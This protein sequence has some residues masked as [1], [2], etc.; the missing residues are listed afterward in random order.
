MQGKVFIQTGKGP[1]SASVS[2]PGSSLEEQSKRLSIQQPIIQ[3][4]RRF[5]GLSPSKNPLNTPTKSALHTED[6]DNESKPAKIMRTQ[7]SPKTTAKRR[8][9]TTKSKKETPKTPTQIIKIP[10]IKK[11][12]DP[13]VA[14]RRIKPVTLPL[15]DSFKK[16][17]ST[18]KLIKFEP[19]QEDWDD[20]NVSVES[21]ELRL[22][23][24]RSF[25][26]C[27]ESSQDVSDANEQ[28]EVE[29]EN[30]SIIETESVNDSESSDQESNDGECSS[31]TVSWTRDDDKILLKTYQQE[32]DSENTFELIHKL[33][34]NRT[35][36][37]I[38]ERFETLINLLVQIKKQD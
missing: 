22:S 9:S 27:E 30:D 8:L 10:E 33:L 28:A 36:K 11:D 5:N 35:V 12:D 24:D 3:C 32:C 23:P 21:I 17:L 6:P 25:G 31:Y 14:K 37:Q 16:V 15:D 26:S 20:C 19:N 18:S 2:F 13:P 1:R 4:K 7:K 34:P 38:K 29:S